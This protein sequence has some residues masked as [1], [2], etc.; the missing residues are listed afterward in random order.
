MVPLLPIAFVV[1]L[2]WMVM[3]RPVPVSPI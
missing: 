2:L 1:F 3:R